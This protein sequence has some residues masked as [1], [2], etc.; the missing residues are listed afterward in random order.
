MSS[1][2]VTQVAVCERYGE[3]AG[4]CEAAKQR[5]SVRRAEIFESVVRGKEPDDELRSLQAQY[6]KSYA[7]LRNHLCGCEL[8]QSARGVAG[9]AGELADVQNSNCGVM[10]A[11]SNSQTEGAGTTQLLEHLRGRL[12]QQPPDALRGH[13]DYDFL[14]EGSE[15]A[16]KA[17]VL[18][19]TYR[20]YMK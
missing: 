1:A 4:E 3:L 8:C 19:A 2:A 11:A 5:W 10:T 14:T 13:A 6:A 15:A 18:H 16:V 9:G 7:A 12:P 20:H 17:A